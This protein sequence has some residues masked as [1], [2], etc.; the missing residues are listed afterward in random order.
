ALKGKGAEDASKIARV[1]VLQTAGELAVGQG[2]GRTEVASTLEEEELSRGGMA[3]SQ[4]AAVQTS[5]EVGQ[6]QAETN[7]IED[8]VAQ[9]VAA[10]S[11]GSSLVSGE[12][13]CHDQPE[14]Q[15]RYGGLVLPVLL[16]QAHSFYNTA[17]RSQLTR[18]RLLMRSPGCARLQPALLLS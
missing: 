5:L 11:Q 15:G 8:E 12:I 3:Q 2:Q 18:Q 9:R 4:D 14:P 7:G 13:V 16:L 1:K 6:G 17:S 10:G